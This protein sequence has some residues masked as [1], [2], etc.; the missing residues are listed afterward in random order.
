MEH[1]MLGQQR[2][3]RVGG[4][5]AADNLA[6]HKSQ[7]PMTLWQGRLSC[8]KLQRERDSTNPAVRT[9]QPLLRGETGFDNDAWPVP[10]G[11]VGRR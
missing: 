4:A 8:I 11:R 7:R 2:L 1:A 10:L 9:A 5:G 3:L 6:V